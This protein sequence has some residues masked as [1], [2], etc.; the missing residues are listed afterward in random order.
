MAVSQVGFLVLPE[1][2]YRRWGPEV[3]QIA[4]A[5]SDN[6]ESR[7]DQL[8]STRESQAASRTQFENCAQ[9][10]S[11]DP[12]SDDGEPTRTASTRRT[13]SHSAEPIRAPTR[14]DV[15]TL[16][17]P[18]ACRGVVGDRLRDADRQVD[19]RREPAE[20]CDVIVHFAEFDPP[21]RGRIPA[22]LNSNTPG[23]EPSSH[24]TAPGDP[25]HSF[26]RDDTRPDNKE[27]DCP[28]RLTRARRLRDATSIAGAE[29]PPRW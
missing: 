2:W 6:V 8:P 11:D 24:G 1:P 5:L 7:R 13:A 22:R 26:G 10:I 27:V 29:G 25:I 18:S 12:G 3:E 21:A 9:V 15:I 17:K 20:I 14:S 4:H 16:R 19:A 28:V 23:G